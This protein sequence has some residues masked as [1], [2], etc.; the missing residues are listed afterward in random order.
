MQ[1]KRQIWGKFQGQ[2]VSLFTLTNKEMEIR[3]TDYGCI[4]THIFVPDNQGQMDDIVLGFDTLQPYLDGHPFFGAIAG[5]FANRIKDGRFS[6]N[7]IQY[8]LATNEL[9]TGQHLH[10]GIRGFDKYLWDSKTIEEDHQIG[11]QFSRVSNDGE[12]GYPG[13]LTIS[14]NIILT[15]K[16]ALIFEFNAQTDQDTIINLVN[17]SY[18]NLQGAKHGD[19]TKQ[20]LQIFADHYTPASED[21]MIPTGKILPVENTGLDFCKAT[22]IGLNMAKQAGGWIDHNFC[23]RSSGAEDGLKK[24]AILYDHQSTRKMV[25]FTNLPGIQC[26]NG[27]KLSN[28]IWMGKDGQQ[29]ENYDGLCLETQYFPDSPNQQNFPSCILKKGEKYHAKTIHQFSWGA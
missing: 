28:Q 16:N 27:F 7:G 26:Y 2:D 11:I 10:G 22:Q 19:I 15:D 13:N 12:E 18:Y 23:I 4:V 25:V 9:S 17:H 5:R 1:I 24:A 21:T 14:H 3:V 29:Y 6:L 20:Y 8:Q